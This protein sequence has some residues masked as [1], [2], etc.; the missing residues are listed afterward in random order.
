M[1]AERK[2]VQKAVFRGKRHDNKIFKVQIVLS[3]HF[4][5]IAQAPKQAR[6]SFAILTLQVSRDMESI[7]A[8]LLRVWGLWDETS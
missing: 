8:G 3:T 1:G 6:K 5:V 4:V 7:A 2:I